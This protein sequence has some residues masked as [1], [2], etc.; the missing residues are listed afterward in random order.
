[1]NSMK[2]VLT[3]ILLLTFSLVISQEI[4]PQLTVDFLIKERN[5]RDQ[6]TLS[7]LNE[8]T[9]EG[10]K[11]IASLPGHYFRFADFIPEPAED[12]IF[13]LLNRA[14]SNGPLYRV[15]FQIYIIGPRVVSNKSPS[16]YWVFR[17][18]DYWDRPLGKH[19][20]R[21]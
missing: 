17:T 11:V 5:Y 15:Y 18:N 16:V 12:T 7:E 4:R 19:S 3:I 13:F 1:M 14:G 6:L 21:S 9:E 20:C 2:Y 10:K 8:Y